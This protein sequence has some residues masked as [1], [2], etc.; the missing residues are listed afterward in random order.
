[1]YLLLKSS[2]R[3]GFDHYL[4]IGMENN[5]ILGSSREHG[6]KMDLLVAKLRK[7]HKKK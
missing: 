5:T 1:M 3:F 7:G 2:K 4:V 6:S